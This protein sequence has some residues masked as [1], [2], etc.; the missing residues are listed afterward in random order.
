MHALY[1]R[2]RCKTTWLTHLLSVFL[3]CLT[4]CLLSS[5]GGSSAGTLKPGTL[6]LVTLPPGAP[7][8]PTPSDPWYGTAG[9]VLVRENDTPPIYT[10]I[11][12][13]SQAN[14][15][16]Y[17]DTFQQASQMGSVF[18]WMGGPVIVNSTNPLGFYFYPKYTDAEIAAPKV[19]QTDLLTLEEDAAC[20]SQ[21][22]SPGFVWLAPVVPIYPQTLSNQSSP[23]A[24]AQPKR[25]LSRGVAPPCGKTRHPGF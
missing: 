5:S 24:V 18:I 4:L 22:P 3:V 2:V 23:A 20:Y 25:G 7:P 21:S 8:Q 1:S 11:G 19:S 16:H 17:L 12:F 14:W 9:N 13:S 15:Q 6:P 10:W